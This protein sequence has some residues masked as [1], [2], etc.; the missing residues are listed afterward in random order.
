MELMSWSKTRRG[1]HMAYE[2]KPIAR[3]MSEVDVSG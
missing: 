3:A 2:I 1:A